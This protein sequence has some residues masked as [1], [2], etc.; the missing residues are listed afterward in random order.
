MPESPHRVVTIRRII[1][2]TPSIRTFFFHESFCFEPGQFVMVWVPGVDEIPMALSS[3]IS[4]SVQ[5]VGDATE[6]LFNLSEGDRMG[7]RGPLGNGFSVEGRTLAI[8]GGIGAAPLVPLAAGGMVDR[9]LL[10]AKTVKEVPFTVAL[11]DCTDLQIA[12]DDGSLGHHGFV[13][14]LLDEEDLRAYE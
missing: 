13:T 2:E 10:G 11:S 8:A 9:F 3:E 6:A 14:D 12:T 7:I 4:I 1:R 5:K